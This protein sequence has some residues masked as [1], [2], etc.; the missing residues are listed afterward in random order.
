[1]LIDG[2]K[3]VWVDIVLDIV[4]DIAI[5]GGDWVSSSSSSCK[6][7][8]GGRVVGG[9]DG[10]A[11]GV[12]VSGDTA[13]SAAFGITGTTDGEVVLLRHRRAL[14]ATAPAVAAIAANA[15]LSR[16]IE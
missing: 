8:S 9:G 2:E 12:S 4:L 5:A 14:A 7:R 3:E 13:L 16:V 1:M 10:P 6:R 11:V 15:V